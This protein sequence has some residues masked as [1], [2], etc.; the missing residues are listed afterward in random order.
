M[1]YLLNHMRVF[2][3]EVVTRKSDYSQVGKA[4]RF[5]DL[6]KANPIYEV[7]LHALNTFINGLTFKADNSYTLPIF[8]HPKFTCALNLKTSV[9]SPKS[10]QPLGPPS[11]S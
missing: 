6:R 7:R 3:I 11:K 2:N 8:S 5:S 10:A 4:L 9:G 1:A